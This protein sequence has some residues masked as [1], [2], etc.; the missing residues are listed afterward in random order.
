MKGQKS[1]A[2]LPAFAQLEALAHQSDNLKR[3]SDSIGSKLSTK[4]P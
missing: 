4:N 3:Q 1:H 2:N